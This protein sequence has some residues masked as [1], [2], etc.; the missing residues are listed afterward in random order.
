MA[1]N[2][3][4]KYWSDQEFVQGFDA[5]AYLMSQSVMRFDNSTD[6]SV[7]LAR[8]L[9]EGMVSYDKSTTS[10][11][12]YDG[13]AW[14]TIGVVGV[15]DHGT[16]VGL[17]DDDHPQYH[18]DTRGDARYYTQTQIDA[19]FA[20]LST[21]HGTLTGL[22][23]D[24]HTQYHNDARGDARYYTQSQV[25]S[26]LS[27]KSDT[28]HAHSYLPLTGGTLTG[29][30]KVQL[31]G[32]E[33]ANFVDLYNTDNATGEKA[34]IKVRTGSGWATTFF[35]QQNNWWHAFGDSNGGTIKWGFDG[36]TLKNLSGGAEFSG[37]VSIG[38]GSSANAFQAGSNY[39]R[40]QDVYG[41]SYF[42]INSGQFYVDSDIYYFRNRASANSLTID[43]SGNGVFR[44]NCEAQ[45]NL[46]VTRPD[47]LML[48]GASDNNHKI[49][50]V[51]AADTGLPWSDGP[52]LV[53]HSGW[54]MYCEQ[55]NV[56]RMGLRGSN[57]NS[58]IRYGWYNCNLMVGSA[59]NDGINTN[60][61]RI[62][63]NQYA[64]SYIECGDQFRNF[65][66][67]G[68]TNGSWNYTQSQIRLDTNGGAAT[69]LSGHPHGGFANM[70]VWA[71]SSS[72]IYFRNW[73]NTTYCGVEGFIYN[74]SHSKYKTNITPL[75]PKSVGSAA[76][77]TLMADTLKRI[78]LVEYEYKATERVPDN[79]E[80]EE[81]GTD[82]VSRQ[83]PNERR[84]RAYDRL[85][86]IRERQG[87]GKYQRLHE[88]GKDCDKTLDD[89]CHIVRNANM[90]IP[91]FLAEEAVE[92]IPGVIA[93][94]EDGEGHS[95][96]LLALSGFL[97]GVVQ[98]LIERVDQLEAV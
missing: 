14:Q 95:V 34:G 33:P 40:P 79:W 64:T 8:S 36:T 75:R 38:T 5:N 31:A 77:R 15:F 96:N 59:P 13:T 42:D 27:G 78:N 84:Q 70:L 98:E 65:R 11:Q 53:G 48:A 44:G 71:R 93:V 16:L 55:E 88:C 43:S 9:V 62:Q 91:G 3:G 54:G 66:A 19:L 41:N 61:L 72:T 2:E 17:G 45:G 73:N 25:D 10:L 94:N 83:V 18:N 32:S 24:D 21:D 76:S 1:R 6:R 92:H 26:S 82:G 97:M 20:G 67:L 90:R 87:L 81:I 23:D 86:D 69:S 22:A 7:S 85:N 58:G 46:V 68:A 80:I 60:T 30:L 37:N 39:W 49:Y 50:S 57:S 4:F 35:T 47:A 56:W 89:P 29:G 28:S 63:G 74:A 51:N 52:V 12:L